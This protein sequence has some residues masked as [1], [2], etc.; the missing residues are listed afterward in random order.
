MKKNHQN[1]ERQFLVVLPED[2]QGAR[3]MDLLAREGAVRGILFF[4]QVAIT[5]SESQLRRLTKLGIDW[6]YATPQ[7]DKVASRSTKT[8]RP[9][10]DRQRVARL[11][12]FR[13]RAFK[14]Y[15]LLP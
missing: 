14:F 10:A 4:N 15:L 13:G 6:K 7:L 8:V 12:P 3:G 1:S 5:A 9:A 2:E 11:S